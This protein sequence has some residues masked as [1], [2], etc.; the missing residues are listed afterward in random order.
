M[1]GMRGW[2]KTLCTL[3]YLEKTVQHAILPDEECTIKTASY[4][5]KGNNLELIDNSVRLIGNGY[6]HSDPAFESLD[7]PTQRAALLFNRVKAK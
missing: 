4:V 6:Q 3:L 1:S 7:D 2:R 5:E